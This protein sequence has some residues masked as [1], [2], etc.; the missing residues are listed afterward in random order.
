MQY[1]WERPRQF[2]ASPFATAAPG[3]EDEPARKRA[4]TLSASPQIIADVL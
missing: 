2:P 3:E 4:S 1:E